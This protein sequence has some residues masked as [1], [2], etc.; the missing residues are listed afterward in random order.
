MEIEK[1]FG[2]EDWGANPKLQGIYQQTIIGD[3][4]CKSSH[5]RMV[6]VKPNVN[7]PPHDHPQLQVFFVLQGK[8]TLRIEND[9]FP[10]SKGSRIIIKPNLLH[11]IE[12]TGK[13]DLLC[14]IFDEFD[15]CFETFSPYVDF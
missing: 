14:L 2:E 12:N 9:E 8:G 11:S 7:T 5:V 13:E 3:E 4:I 1:R 6:K 10:I 15:K